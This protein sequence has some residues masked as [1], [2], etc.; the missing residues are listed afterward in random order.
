MKI[1]ALNLQ[2]ED[3]RGDKWRWSSEIKTRSKIEI[4]PKVVQI[5]RADPAD[6]EVVNRGCVRTL[7][8]ALSTHSRCSIKALERFKHSSF[9][10]FHFFC[11]LVLHNLEIN[12]FWSYPSLS[13]PG[14]TLWLLPSLGVIPPLH[15]LSVNPSNI[16]DA[17][18][19]L[20]R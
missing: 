18:I 17:L 8:A 9:R 1:K 19:S 10:C 15:S 16:S 6:S 14:S 2:I 7:S 3:W 5:E 20:D 11:R 12:P 4:L 13:C